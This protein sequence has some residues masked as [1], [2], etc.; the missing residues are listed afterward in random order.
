MVPPGPLDGVRP[1]TFS[2]LLSPTLKV[3]NATVGTVP[4]GFWGA[5]VRA[6]YGLGALQSS[7]FNATPLHYIRWPGG[8]VGDRYNLSANR[9]YYDNGGSMTPGSSEAQFAKWCLAVNCRAI[10][11]L[12]AEINDPAAAAYYVAYSETTLGFHPAYWEIGD[13]PALWTH[14]GI[15]WSNWTTAQSINATPTTYA[16]VVHAYAAAIHIVDPTAR[17]VGLAGVGTGGY[18]EDVWIRA[19]V[20]LNGPNLSAVGIHVYPAGGPIPPGPVSISGF[21]GTLDGK[22][23]LSYRIPVDRQAIT[24]ACPTCHGIMIFVTEL[25]ST[26]TGSPYERWTSGPAIVPYLAAEIAQGLVLGVPNMDLFAFQGTYNGSILNET[27]VPSSVSTLYSSIF[28]RVQSIILNATVKTGPGHLFVVA[29]VDPSYRNYSLLIVN[30]NSSYSVK[31]NLV[32]SGFPVLGSGTALAWNY[33]AAAPSTTSWSLV[34]SFSY[35]V[36]SK[37]VL[38]LQIHV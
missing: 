24:A 25:G 36:P 7:V 23:A 9:I 13:E 22:G 34:S 28:P 38:I 31:L 20:A 21:L 35:T 12:P 33:S 37:S 26:T 14:F 1:A 19:T 11:Q 5:D 29:S 4:T 6:Y 30:A 15:P 32:G 18:N 16:A 2:G 3:V 17:I 10:V 8:A 27:G